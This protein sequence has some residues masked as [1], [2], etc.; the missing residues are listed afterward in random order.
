[1]IKDLGGFVLW[2]LGF[3]LQVSGV[4]NCPKKRETIDVG[5]L[6]LQRPRS[7]TTDNSNAFEGFCVLNLDFCSPSRL[8]TR[9]EFQ[10]GALA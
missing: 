7:A 6:E 3:K 1:M 9:S 5:V 2:I 4:Q 8:C 10:A